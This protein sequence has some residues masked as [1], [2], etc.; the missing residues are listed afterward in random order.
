MNNLIDIQGQIEKLQKQANEIRTRE[1]QKT[2]KEILAMMHAFGI[3]AKDLGA[4]SG[5]SNKSKGPK[6]AGPPQRARAK[7]AKSTA[8][9]TV[10]PK[11]RG[12]NGETWT[13]R[14]LTPRWLVSLEAEGRQ[15]DDFAI[16]S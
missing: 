14:G 1:F 3:T 2:V 6:K 8:G 13:G 4:A 12:P 15:K 11:Y 9:T 7:P 5:K 16:K 10:A